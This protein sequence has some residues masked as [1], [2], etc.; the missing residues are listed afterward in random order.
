MLP[1]LGVLD[2]HAASAWV[3]TF[4]FFAVGLV[5]WE[6]LCSLLWHMPFWKV[7]VL[8]CRLIPGNVEFHP[9]TY[10]SSNFPLCFTSQLGLCQSFWASSSG[11]RYFFPWLLFPVSVL[12]VV[13]RS[14]WLLLGT[15][16][17]DGS[18]DI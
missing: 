5:C 3:Q 16:V 14:W 6:W 12:F 1:G 18:C 9:E 11:G 2:C 8:M 4:D 15:L 17:V 10:L 7:Q 13:F